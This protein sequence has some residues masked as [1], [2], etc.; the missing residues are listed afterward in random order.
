M[1]M[2]AALLVASDPAVAPQQP[3]QPSPVSAAP[4]PKQV[5]ERKICKDDGEQFT[6]TRTHKQL[7]LTKAEWKLKEA[8]EAADG[9]RE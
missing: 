5:K 6:G 2:L 1:M 7:C 4:A 3:P 9:G 8:A